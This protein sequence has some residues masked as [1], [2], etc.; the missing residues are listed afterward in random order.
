MEVQSKMNNNT[1][2]EYIAPV[3]VLVAIC[4]VVT[5]ILAFVNSITAPI[6]EEN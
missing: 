6:I 4:L 5:G 2:K 3:V 1:F